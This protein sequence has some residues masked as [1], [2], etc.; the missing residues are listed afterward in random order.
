MRG[1]GLVILGAGLVWLGSG[2]SKVDDHIFTVGCL[3]VLVGCGAMVV[4]G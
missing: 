2:D 3:I 1:L 4:F